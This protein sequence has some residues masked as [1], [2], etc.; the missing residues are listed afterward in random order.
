M[1]T[2]MPSARRILAPVVLVLLVGTTGL[3]PTSAEPTP[4]QP[5]WQCLPEETAFAVRIPDGRAVAKAFLENTKLGAV[6]FSD[7]RM[8]AVTELLQDEDSQGWSK[9]QASLTEYGFTVDDLINL[10]AGE[11]GYAVVISPHD[12]QDVPF[13]AGLAWLQPGSA[14]AERVCTAVGEAVQK[15]EDDEHPIRRVDSDV[16][17]RHVIQLTV[18]SIKIEYDDDWDLPDDYAELS[19]QEQ[20]RVWKEAL[21]KRE[22][23]AVTK[24]TYRTVLITTIG[25]RLLLAHTYHNVDEEDESAEAEQ[26]TTLL[27]RWIASHANAQHSFAARYAQTPGAADV[28]ELRGVA[29]FEMLGDVPALLKLARAESESRD[30]AEQV[31]RMLGADQLGTF[32]LR[33]T[34]L[35]SQWHT[36]YFLAAPEPRHGLLELVEQ[37]PLSTEP[38]PWVPASVIRFS[39]WSFDLGKAYAIVKQTV[40]KEFP[41]ESEPWFQRTEA[42]LSGVTQANLGDILSAL[43]HRHTMLKFEPLFVGSADAANGEVPRVIERTAIVWQVTDEDMWSRVLQSLAPFAGMAPG[44]EFKEEQGFRGWRLETES[45]EGGLFLGKGYLV[46]AQGPDVL[47][48]VLSSLNS[49][50][51]G[52]GAL[53][54]SELYAHASSVAELRPCVMFDLA[55]GNRIAKVVVTA[56]DQAIR[57]IDDLVNSTHADEDQ[58]ASKLWLAVTR[59]LVPTEEEVEGT[60]GVIVSSWEVNEHGMV[61]W[62]VQ[63]LPP[64]D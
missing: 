22:D 27:A 36:R 21:R 33:S 51:E 15:H 1:I 19:E 38:P 34:L 31:L 53:R 44:L 18:P 58:D 52:S 7:E 14:L 64:A 2:P 50:P 17:Q 45:F 49:P 55:D 35:G 30:H 4:V 16:E 57:Q 59:A 11:S 48:T 25:D 5:T 3:S 23:S 10:F 12:Q 13:V 56:I 43:G 24:I 39:Q 42:Q 46:Y 41:E 26:L 32:S 61:G 54:G 47:A 37:T 62:S 60:L 29:T 20:E 6:L 40:L 9:F 28:F 8:A 63:E